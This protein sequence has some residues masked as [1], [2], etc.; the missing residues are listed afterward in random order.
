MIEQLIKL[1]FSDGEAKVYVAALELGETSVARIAEKAKLERTTVYGFLEGLKKRG[2][3]SISKEHKKTVYAAENPKKLRGDIDERWKLVET[4]LPELLSITNV[5]SQKPTVRFFDTKEG[6][7][8]IYRETLEYPSQT[9]NIWMSSPWFDDEKYFRDIY[10]PT[11][12][13]KGILIR[14]IIPKNDETIP[15]AKDDATSLRETRMTDRDDITA[16]IV[17][18]GDRNIAAISY[19]ESTAIV[20]ESKPLYDTLRVAFEAH[21]QLLSSKRE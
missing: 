9:V 3:I 20:I 19:K 12:I 5:I 1:G 2:M 18:Y 16:D 10:M 13:E 7:I 15:F 4:L 17:M 21:W 6:I 8:D 14:A 11:R